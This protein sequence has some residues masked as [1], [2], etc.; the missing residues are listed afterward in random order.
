MIP[1]I[2]FGVFIEFLI[3]DHTIF[4]SIAATAILIPVKAFCTSH[5]SRWSQREKALD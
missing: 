1:K 3:K 2:F 4:V 5:M